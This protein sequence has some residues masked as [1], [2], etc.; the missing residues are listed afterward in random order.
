MCSHASEIT[1]SGY[2]MW[3]WCTYGTFGSLVWSVGEITWAQHFLSGFVL[4]C[5]W[6]WWQR[7]PDLSWDVQPRDQRVD[8]SHQHAL[9]SQWSWRRRWSWTTAKIAISK[10]LDWSISLMVADLMAWLQSRRPSQEGHSLPRWSENQKCQ[11]EGERWG[12]GEKGEEGEWQWCLIC[13]V[14]THLETL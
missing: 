1:M 4:W 7:L 2:V 11:T 12:I 10:M 8:R 14:P 13:L 6:L 9:R 3:R 5:R